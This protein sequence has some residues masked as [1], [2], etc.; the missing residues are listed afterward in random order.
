MLRPLVSIQAALR[1]TAPTSF[2]NSI[3]ACTL[4]LRGLGS[5]S[6]SRDRGV[7]PH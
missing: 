2:S 5:V 7:S 4:A 1:T 3:E 6:A